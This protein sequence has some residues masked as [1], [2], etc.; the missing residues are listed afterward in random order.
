MKE[1]NEFELPISMFPEAFVTH[2]GKV[3]SASTR[4]IKKSDFDEFRENLTTEKK[5]VLGPVQHQYSNFMK[6]ID[7][8]IHQEEISILEDGSVD[9]NF[10]KLEKEI[11]KRLEAAKT[12]LKKSITSLS[13]K[14]TLIKSINLGYCT[15]RYET[16][17]LKEETATAFKTRTSKRESYEVLLKYE[18]MFDELV[19][20]TQAVLRKY[21]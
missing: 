4:V 16:H 13:K 7:I 18:C 10:T 2:F 5:F 11:Q 19:S 14:G 21:K 8:K 1:D 9:I 3:K 12:A 6:D 17:S 15:A 20:E